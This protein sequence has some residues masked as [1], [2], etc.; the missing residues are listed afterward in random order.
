[1]KSSSAKKLMSVAGAALLLASCTNS[2]YPGYEKAENGLYYQFYTQNESAIK[3]NMGDV[4]RVVMSY[5]NSKDSV[6]FDTKAPDPR[7]PQGMDYLEMQLPKSTFAGSFEDALSM[8]GVGDSASFKISADSVYLKTFG[9]PQLPPYIEKGSM[10]TFDVKM[11]KITSKADAEAQQKKRME[12]QQKMMAAKNE[13]ERAAIEKYVADKKI[14]ATPTASGLYYIEITKG[15][16]AHAQAGQMVK[17]NYTGRLL[18]GTVFDTSDEKAAK[19][20]GTYNEGRP[21]EPYE[22]QLGAQ[23]VIAGWDEAIQLM[24]PGGKAK[25]IV[26]SSLAYG[27]QPNGPIPA[28]STL[29]FDVELVSVSNTPSAPADGKIVNH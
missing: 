5:K 2:P 8:M 1:M 18:D 22:F 6:L 12:E 13:E 16:G 9:A 7:K 4:V 11:E 21:Y 24:S 20:A 3:P 25:L 29:E 17:V 19:A 23:Q 27:P 26:P 28:F 10:L 14:T 15:K